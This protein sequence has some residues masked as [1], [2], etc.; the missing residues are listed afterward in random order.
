MHVTTGGTLTVILRIFVYTV[1]WSIKLATNWDTETLSHL[2]SLL[3]EMSKRRVA[4]ET[5]V[6]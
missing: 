5:L 6:A 3:I 4:L 1:G 2:K